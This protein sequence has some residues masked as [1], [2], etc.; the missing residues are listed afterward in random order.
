LNIECENELGRIHEILFIGAALNDTV[1]CQKAMNTERKEADLILEDKCYQNMDL[2]HKESS[3]QMNLYDSEEDFW[4]NHNLF[5]KP[6]SRH[7][8]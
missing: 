4:N 1:N 2:I 5:N 8:F 6:N 7:F 3:I